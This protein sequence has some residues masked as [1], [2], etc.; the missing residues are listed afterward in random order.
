MNKYGIDVSRYN[1]KIDWDKVKDD[2]V[3]FAIL[4]TVS[5]NNKEF[6]GIYIDPQFERNYSE[7][8][9]LGI[10]VGIYYYTYATQEETV[11]KELEKLDEAIAGKTFEYPIW[12]DAEDKS[13]IR[14]GKK[15]LTDMIIL[16]AK[17][18][19]SWGY[20]V[21]YYSYT[22]YLKQY[23][24]TSRLKDFDCWI[25]QYGKNTGKKPWEKSTWGEPHGIWQYS[26]TGKVAG[27]YGNNGNVDVNEAYK[28]YPSIMKK[29]GLNGFEKDESIELP[30]AE[31][32]KPVEKI[33]MIGAKVYYKGYLY[34]NSN[35]GGRGKWVVGHY[36]VTRYIKGRS[37]GVHLNGLGWVSEKDCVLM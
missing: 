29:Y 34:K 4:K 7:C 26:S 22:S 2:G 35:G 24:D 15:Q 30:E 21:G 8:K 16:A 28:D 13:I 20:Y 11:R 12:I 5:T 19:E 31:V 9:R 3:E 18:I 17:E 36:T 37:H 25:A 10:P 23:V 1:G 27:I 14:R 6:G 33:M 32:I